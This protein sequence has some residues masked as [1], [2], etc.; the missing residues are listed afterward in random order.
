M[1]KSSILWAREER[2]SK[3]AQNSIF[4]EFMR[5]CP[6]FQSNRYNFGVAK[7]LSIRRS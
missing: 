3:T 4:L 1:V 2:V 6:V 5:H 7:P